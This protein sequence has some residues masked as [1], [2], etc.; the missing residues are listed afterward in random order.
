MNQ[1]RVLGWTEIELAPPRTGV[2]AWYSRMRISKADVNDTISR[3]KAAVDSQTAHNL[4]ENAL[5][6]FIFNPY[7]ES[8]Y[9][10]LLRGQLKPKFI[11]DV[12]HE[13]SRSD[14]LVTRLAR[15]PERLHVIAALLGDA[16][17]AFTS[18]LYIGMAVNLRARLRTHKSKIT[19]FREQRTNTEADSTPEAGFARQ[20]VD[21]G[22]DPTNLFVHIAEVD[23]EAG[24]HNDIENILNRINYPIFGRN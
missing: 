15:N 18:P 7:R 10:V 3:V 11:G 24:E 4:I 14:S 12:E 9:R 6:R 20:V 23:V 5:D 1:F 2:Y 17:P 19:E 22:F 8:P 13:P 16:A 21:R